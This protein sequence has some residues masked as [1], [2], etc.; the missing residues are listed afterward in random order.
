MAK[1]KT[2][3]SCT[4]KKIDKGRW[5]WTVSYLNEC[6]GSG[7]AKTQAACRP[8]KDRVKK[9]W[10][11]ENGDKITK[12]IGSAL[13]GKCVAGPGGMRNRQNLIIDY[14]P[15]SEDMNVPAQ[16]IPSER[17]ATAPAFQPA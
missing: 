11:A 2:Q 12:Y 13:D 16:S 3:F 1:G 9:E 5:R 10:L 8:E 17:E 6:I 4:E 7:I 15:K 14:P